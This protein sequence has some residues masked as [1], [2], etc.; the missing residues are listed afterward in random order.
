MLTIPIFFAA[1]SALLGGVYWSIAE[2]EKW[3]G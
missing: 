2:E 3:E 1:L